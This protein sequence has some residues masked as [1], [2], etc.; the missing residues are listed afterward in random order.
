MFA[1]T[2]SVVRVG[3]AAQAMPSHLL[4]CLLHLHCS[5]P[6]ARGNALA[7]GRL[8]YCMACSC[9][10]DEIVRRSIACAKLFQP[11]E[12]AI[13]QGTVQLP[14]EGRE[15][16]I[17]LFPSAHLEWLTKPRHLWR[18][19]GI[20]RCARQQANASDSRSPSV[21]GVTPEQIPAH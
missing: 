11:V 15:T 20:W 21:S 5:L 10:P 9:G 19:V 17:C 13:P 4:H 8:G 7:I 14:Q 2:N 18:P 1:P 6:R 3:F 12:K 16:L